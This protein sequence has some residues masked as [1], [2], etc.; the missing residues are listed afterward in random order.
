[1]L[2]GELFCSGLRIKL[3]TLP[4]LSFRETQPGQVRNAANA[5]R[6]FQKRYRCESIN[7][8]VD[9]RSTVT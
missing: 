3:K 9:A 1:M 8:H 4:Q 5:A 2:V 6:P 7:V